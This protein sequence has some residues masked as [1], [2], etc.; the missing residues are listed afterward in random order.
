MKK[1]KVLPALIALTLTLGNMTGLYAAEQTSET[2]Q[3]TN[4]TENNAENKVE[5]T[6]E[7]ERSANGQDLGETIVSAQRRSRG[8]S[9]TRGS[10]G[11]LG[12]L[13]SMKTPFTTTNITE[14]SI[15]SF[16]D[17][18]QTLDSIL[19]QSPAIRQSGS[20]LHNDFTFRGFRANGTSTYVNGIPG[21]WT[22]FHNEEGG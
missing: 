2:R 13:D 21:I 9:D 14:E 5:K 22:Q 12:N 3:E 16:G 18:T 4:E 20:I 1:H 11:F 15:R 19:A 6:Q 10:V 7:V 17:P 8:F